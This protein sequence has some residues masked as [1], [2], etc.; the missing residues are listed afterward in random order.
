LLVGFNRR[1]VWQFLD[2]LAASTSQMWPLQISDEEQN[3]KGLR[4]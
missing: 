1:D 4:G 2:F 3:E